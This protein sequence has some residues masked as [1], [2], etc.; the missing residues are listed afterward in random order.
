MAREGKSRVKKEGGMILEQMKE[1]K[2]IIICSCGQCKLE[3]I[4]HFVRCS[5]CGNKSHELLT[6]I[7]ENGFNEGALSKV[8]EIKSILDISN[9]GE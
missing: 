5:Y 2:L 3:V 6:E 1:H 7:W 8:D 9:S 4:G